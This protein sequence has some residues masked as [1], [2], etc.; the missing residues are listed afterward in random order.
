[1]IKILETFGRDDLAMVYVARTE[2]GKTLEFVEA[3]VPPHPRDEKWVI[4]VSTL[5]GC[6]IGCLMCDSGLHYHGKVAESDLLAQIDHVVTRRFP[7]RIIETEKLKIHFARMGDP[8][9]NHNV[10]KVLTKL[11]GLYETP[12]LMPSLSTVA[13]CGTDDFFLELLDVRRTCYPEGNFQLQFSIHTTDSACRDE[14]IPV[15]KWD[16][17]RIVQYGEMF[18]VPDGGRKITLNFAASTRYPVDPLVIGRRFN[19]DIFMIKITPLNPSIS[20]ERNGL[21]SLVSLDPDDAGSLELVRSFEEHGYDVILSIGEPEE[22]RIGSNC[23]LRVSD[24]AASSVAVKSD[25]LM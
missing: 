21:D 8:A 19:P 16:F 5:Y 20:T 3:L 14:L 7:S 13:P 6:P 10:N 11:K 4:I 17:S 23:G 2:S 22:N 24:V 1:M 18:F 25:A 12:N 9:F 15:R